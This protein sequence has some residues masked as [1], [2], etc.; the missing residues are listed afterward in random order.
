MSFVDRT[1]A[2]RRLAQKLEHL[3]GSNAVVVGLPRGG[4]PVAFEVA[5]ALEAPLDVI[6]VRKLGVP[7]QPELGM[8]AIGED[9][10]RVINDEVVRRGRRHSASSPRSSARTGRA[11]PAAPAV[12]RRP[13]TD[14]AHGPHRGRRRRRDRHRL[15]GAGRLPGR[16]GRRARARVVARRTGR[17]ARWTVGARRRTT[18]TRSCASETPEPFFAIGAVLCRLHPD[19]R[20]GGRAPASNGPR[21]VH[22]RC[23]PTVGAGRSCRSS[24][25]TWRSAPGRYGLGGHLDRSRGAAA[26]SCSPTAAA[27]AGTAPATGTWRRSSTGAGLGTLLFDLLTPAEEHDRANVFDIELLA[28]PAGRRH[29]LA[30]RPT[31]TARPADRL[32]RRQHRRRRRAVGRR[33]TRRRHRRGRLPRRPPGSRRAAARRRSAPRPC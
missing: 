11:G 29:R 14:P 30:A 16:P 26:S 31:R 2:G 13:A 3:R 33:R 17:T 4:V 5:S 10:V 8:G 19:H 20:R 1:D 24:T 25:A 21:A 27:A 9:D 6:V 28:A 15:D 32:L 18:P 22:R 23:R 7:F 12:P